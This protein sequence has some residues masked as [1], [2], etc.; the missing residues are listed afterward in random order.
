MFSISTTNAP[1]VLDNRLTHI[2]TDSVAVEKTDT[3]WNDPGAALVSTATKAQNTRGVFEI[4]FDIWN[5]FGFLN[6]NLLY[7]KIR[8]NSHQFSP[9]KFLVDN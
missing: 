8:V 5:S 4:D 7:Q 2:R 6:K 3:E 9:N 1:S